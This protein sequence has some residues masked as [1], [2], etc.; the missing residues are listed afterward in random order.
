MKKNKKAKINIEQITGSGM[1]IVIGII[2]SILL[3]LLPLFLIFV[4]II[5][6]A[7]LL[8]RLTSLEFMRLSKI[9]KGIS[10]F[11][12]I[13]QRFSE[14]YITVFVTSV[15]FLGISFIVGLAATVLYF[16]PAL[17][18]TIIPR[19]NM[20]T[21]ALN[22]LFSITIGFQYL[23][24]GMVYE[25]KEKFKLIHLRTPV[26]AIFLIVISFLFFM[27]TFFSPHALTLVPRVMYRE[28]IGDTT[29]I[30]IINNENNPVPVFEILT[31][32]NWSKEHVAIINRDTPFIIPPHDYIEIQI[33]LPKYARGVAVV[34][35]SGYPSAAIMEIL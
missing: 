30:F 10:S 29:T 20:P 26:L 32:D 14:K 5:L 4:L 27:M 13:F 2:S 9:I 35:N 6:P 16:G 21:Y 25:H 23:L 31:I 18:V 19:L 8:L 33:N 11:F 7:I 22:W 34:D 1:L 15:I 24:V 28:E 17:L 12:P 3:Y